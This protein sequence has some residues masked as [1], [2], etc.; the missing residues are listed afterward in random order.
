MW[1][2]RSINT[3]RMM[4]K[5]RTK[6]YFVEVCAANI[7]MKSTFVKVPKPNYFQNRRNQ[8]EIDKDFFRGEL[9]E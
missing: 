1:V 5:I 4:L 6:I 9:W 2:F 7:R 8:T 3:G